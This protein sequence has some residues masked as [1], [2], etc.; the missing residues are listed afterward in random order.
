MAG[1]GGQILV[2][3][4]TRIARTVLL[5]YGVESF[6]SKLAN[7]VESVMLVAGG[8]LLIMPSWRSDVVAIAIAAPAVVLHIRPVLPSLQVVGKKVTGKLP[9]R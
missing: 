5:A 6:I 8:I 7:W 4:I 1:S 2:A 3:T 9:E